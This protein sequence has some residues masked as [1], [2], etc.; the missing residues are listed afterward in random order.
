MFQTILTKMMMTSTTFFFC[1]AKTFAVM[2][3]VIIKLCLA[4]MILF[5]MAVTSRCADI[6]YVVDFNN[7]SRI[8][9]VLPFARNDFFID[10]M[11]AAADKDSAFG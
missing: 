10:Y 5:I 8:H 7:G 1:V 11:E 9:I 2:N 4:F 6:T 3:H